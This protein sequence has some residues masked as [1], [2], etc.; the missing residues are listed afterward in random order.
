M[1]NKKDVLLGVIYGFITPVIA[2]VFWVY[3]FSDYEI[4]KAINLVVKGNLYSEVISLSAIANFAVM[5]L[6]LN[7]RKYDSG[8]GVLLSTILLSFAVIGIKFFA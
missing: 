1:I 8:R 7:K 5:L 2:F 3:L 6:L 4:Q